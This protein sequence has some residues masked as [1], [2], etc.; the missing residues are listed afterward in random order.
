METE[1][2]L[3]MEHRCSLSCP[4]CSFIYKDFIIRIYS[5]NPSSG[6]HMCESCNNAFLIEVELT[7]NKKIRTL[8]H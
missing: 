2:D 6:T 4:N 7:V 5:M 1:G 3:Y 8:P